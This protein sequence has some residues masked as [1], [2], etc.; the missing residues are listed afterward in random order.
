MSW[1]PDL[2]LAFGDHR[3]RPAIDLMARIPLEAPRRIVDLGCGPG[4]VTKLLAERWPEAET[5]GIDNSSAML[6]RARHDFPT[7]AFR[8]GDIAAWRGDPP[9]DLIFTNA[10][11]HW[12]DD[13][14]HLF[15]R[16]L[17]QL[18]PS[19]VLAAQMP[20]NFDA[21]SHR[22]LCETAEAGPWRAKLAPLLHREPVRAPAAYH[23]ILAPLARDLDI[24]ESEYLHLLSGEDPV[25]A[26]NKATALRPFLDALSEPE[27]SAFEAEYGARLRRAYPREADGRTLYPFRRLFIIARR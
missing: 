15:P 18:N 19:G 25:A 24:W 7:L 11:L 1:N 2:Y 13:H 4:H 17:A 12:L 5:V 6:E 8:L 23:R 10:A 22:A 20:R 21:P 3:L 9:V 14:D 26:W 16:L 27:R